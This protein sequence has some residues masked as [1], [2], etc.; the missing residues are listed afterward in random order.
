MTEKLLHELYQ[1]EI[2][3]VKGAKIH[4]NMILELKGVKCSKT[5][6]NVLERQYAKSKNDWVIY[7]DNMQNQKMTELYTDDKKTKYSSNPND[8]LKSVPNFYE[9]LYSKT[10]TFSKIHNRTKISNEKSHL[11]EVEISLKIYKHFFE[12]TNLYL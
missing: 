12:W 8:L 11:C 7:K 3:F 1:L 2:E 10:A 9:K 6:F 5:Y 4:P